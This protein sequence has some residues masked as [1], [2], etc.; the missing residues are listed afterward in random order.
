MAVPETAATVTKSVG[1]VGS[2]SLLAA[3]AESTDFQVLV[4]IG[5]VISTLSFLYDKNDNKLPITSSIGS[6]LQWTNYVMAGVFMAV[7]V[8]YV[9]DTYI[10][11]IFAMPRTVWLTIAGFC[12]GYALNIIRSSVS[13]FLNIVVRSLELWMHRRI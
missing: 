10:P 8:F 3:I 12:S 9:L 5:L 6:F 13:I 11:S 4:V 2:A 1:S 7:V